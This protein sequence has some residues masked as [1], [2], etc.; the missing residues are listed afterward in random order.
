MASSVKVDW[1]ALRAAYEANKEPVE[2]LAHRFGISVSSLY[3]RAVREAWPGRMPARR[4]GSG[5]P[6][7]PI[8]P[9]APVKRNR[10]KAMTVPQIRARM[11]EVLTN[12]LEQLAAI[13]D[14]HPNDSALSERSARAMATIVNAIDKL[15]DLE[16]KGGGKPEEPNP[17]RDEKVLHILRAELAERLGLLGPL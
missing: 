3:H 4:R 2:A 8:T 14:R 9:G 7:A 10:R 12:Q 1:A 15:I 11:L 16:L 13:N 6:P 17:E 5:P